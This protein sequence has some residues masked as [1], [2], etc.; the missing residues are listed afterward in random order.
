MT[1]IEKQYITITK[2]HEALSQ[3]PVCSFG[4]FAC[5]T[6][7]SLNRTYD[8]LLWQLMETCSFYKNPL[9]VEMWEFFED[10]DDILKELTDDIPCCVGFTEEWIIRSIRRTLDRLC[11]TISIVSDVIDDHL[12]VENLEKAVEWYE[13]LKENAT[14]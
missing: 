13:Q 1:I 3:I 12:V 14:K 2:L 9:T 4:Y 10:M 5:L 6:L 11:E 8:W 7:E